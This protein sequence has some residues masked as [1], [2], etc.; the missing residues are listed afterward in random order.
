MGGVDDD[1]PSVIPV[2]RCNFSMDSFA[3][4]SFTTCYMS[5]THGFLRDKVGFVRAAFRST[6]SVL[7]WLLKTFAWYAGAITTSEVGTY[8]GA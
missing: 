4:R 2:I 7:L 6:S 1:L 5:L 8:E 3:S